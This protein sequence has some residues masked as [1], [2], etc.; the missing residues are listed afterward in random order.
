[1][2]VVQHQFLDSFQLLLD[3][4][5]SLFTAD[6]VAEYT[7]TLEKLLALSGWN[8]AEFMSTK[9]TQDEVGYV[10]VAWCRIQEMRERSTSWKQSLP[11]R[12]PEHIIDISDQATV[13][14]LLATKE[15]K[16]DG[17]AIGTSLA[18]FDHPKWLIK[19][20]TMQIMEWSAFR[21]LHSFAKDQ[22]QIHALLITRTAVAASLVRYMRLL[23]F[24]ETDIS[25][26]IPV[27]KVQT[28]AGQLKTY[29][30]FYLQNSDFNPKEMSL[31]KDILYG[32]TSYL[33]DYAALYFTNANFFTHP[34]PKSAVMNCLSKAVREPILEAIESLKPGPNL[35]Q[36][37]M[38]LDGK[39]REL[40][41]FSMIRFYLFRTSGT[42][43][44]IFDYTIHWHEWLTQK[45][46]T[47]LFRGDILR[48]SS[49]MEETTITPIM[50]AAGNG[51]WR[52]RWCSCIYRFEDPFSCMA[53]W[54]VIVTEMQHSRTDRYASVPNIPFENAKSA[55]DPKAFRLFDATF[56]S[57]V[58]LVSVNPSP[59]LPVDKK[60]NF[61]DTVVEA[62][63]LP[64][65][66]SFKGNQH[67]NDVSSSDIGVIGLGG[68]ICDDDDDD[69]DPD[70]DGD[71]FPVV[72]AVT[73][74]GAENNIRSQ[75]R[76]SDSSSSSSSN[77]NNNNNSSNSSSSSSNIISISSNS[78]DKKSNDTGNR[79]SSN[80][81]PSA[82]SN[83]AS[84]TAARSAP[85]QSTITIAKELRTQIPLHTPHDNSGNEARQA[86]PMN[87]RYQKL[88][89]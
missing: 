34:P 18:A 11:D 26:I 51:K 81:K 56:K 48:E 62:P 25:E 83:D 49:F 2:D 23:F 24:A 72:S 38:Q 4:D 88:D 41:L 9:T 15:F 10:G 29:A 19:N 13:D 68:M 78:S 46:H 45:A 30:M 42:L 16:D 8:E 66:V 59:P 65:P 57:S 85:Q 31:M 80:D 12:I 67:T 44:D 32:S 6:E 63:T 71:V 28:V 82:S 53:A 55:F 79:S 40:V 3:C 74:T 36:L 35:Y 73:A 47:R 52:L 84:P 89:M 87:R 76:N 58:P 70:E 37:C 17:T 69:D 61:R 43:M 33:G 5:V 21:R 86:H 77:N 60:V 64:M 75:T 27:N 1:M 54:W 20:S 7:A 22:P 14:T 39:L 50:L